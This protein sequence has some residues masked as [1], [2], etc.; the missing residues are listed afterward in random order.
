MLGRTRNCI[1]EFH[2]FPSGGI[3]AIGFKTN[4]R[5]KYLREPRS[6]YDSPRLICQISPRRI[7]THRN[8]DQR[9]IDRWTRESRDWLSTVNLC[10]LGCRAPLRYRIPRTAHTNCRTHQP[11]PIFAFLAV[12]SLKLGRI[13]DGQVHSPYPERTAAHC[14]LPKSI[15]KTKLG[16][17]RR[18]FPSPGPTHGPGGELS[19]ARTRRRTG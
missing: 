8:E 3:S 12:G 2:L 7:T 10:T 1:L 4:W 19:A 17:G 14:A 16:A 18:H 13:S 11:V 6:P 9:K 15:L 5:E